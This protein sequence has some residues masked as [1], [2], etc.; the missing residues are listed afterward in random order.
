VAEWEVERRVDGA[1]RVVGPDGAPRIAHA[2]TD[3]DGAIWI[4][5]DGE[6]VVLADETTRRPRPQ[7]HGH[8]TLEAPM[9]AQVTAVLV[10]AG[11][12]VKAGDT[13]LLLEA[14]KMELPLKA[15]TAGRVDAIHCAV[16]QRVAP[17]RVLVDLAAGKAAS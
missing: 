15:P 9:P 16:G 14:M 3:P 13:L 11:D 6:V 5:L 1:W 10:A 17:G 8:A 7:P 2:V 4:H 12:D